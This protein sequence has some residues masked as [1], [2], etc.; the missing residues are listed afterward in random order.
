[1]G[2]AILLPML[3]V[4]LALRWGGWVAPIPFDLGFAAL[5]A[6]GAVSTLR[7]FRA[8]PPAL[9]CF[10]VLPPVLCV[11]AMLARPEI[12]LSPYLAIATVNGFVACAFCRG[13]FNRRPGP[14]PQ[15]V[16]LT[17][18]GPEG[19]AEWRLYIR[20]QNWAWTVFG[21]LTA[22]TALAAMLSPGL[23]PLLDMAL[24]AEAGF[25]ILWFVASHE[26][27]QWRHDRP[28]SWRDTIRSLSRPGA[29]RKL[30]F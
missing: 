21:G 17:G 16:R 9:L 1:M 29:W 28:E 2:G 4:A 11:A 14:I 13:L 15:I 20:W 6:F 25:Q 27:A 18:I 22:V 19:G 12:R 7:R 3:L 10:G 5:V 24:L 26:Y 8:P 30:E 23:R